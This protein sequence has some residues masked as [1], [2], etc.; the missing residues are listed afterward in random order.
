MDTP[1]PKR[2]AYALSP[3]GPGY[4]GPGA[5]PTQ[6]TGEPF[7]ADS[8]YFPFSARPGSRLSPAK[9]KVVTP[10]LRATK[11][12]PQQASAALDNPQ[13]VVSSLA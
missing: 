9:A 5:S 3:A 6:A 4:S 1:V 11:E 7:A 2:G 13:W 12:E 10:G 8:P